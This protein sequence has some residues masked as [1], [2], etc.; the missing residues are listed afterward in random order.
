MATGR[1]GAVDVNAAT[2]TTIYTAP[3]GKY[4]ALTVSIT[5]RNPLGA[6][7]RLGLSATATPGNAEWLEYDAILKANGILE[8]TGIIVGAGQYLV[9]Y[10]S[11]ASVNFIAYGIEDI[12]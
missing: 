12:Q 6:V 1:L 10:S 2:N 5:C 8:R 9:A 11:V 7:V 4:A 3:A